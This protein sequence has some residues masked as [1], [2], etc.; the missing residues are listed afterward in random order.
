LVNKDFR[1]LNSLVFEMRPGMIA[2]GSFCFPMERANVGQLATVNLEHSRVFREAMVPVGARDDWR[3]T[4]QAPQVLQFDAGRGTS[5]PTPVWPD[6]AADLG[7][8]GAERS[9]LIAVAKSGAEGGGLEQCL[10]N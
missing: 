4:N 7:A 9:T 5:A 2:Q 3:A 1:R 8:A 6:A 10:R